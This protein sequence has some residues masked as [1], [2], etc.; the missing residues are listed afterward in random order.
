MTD[1]THTLAAPAASM[2]TSAEIIARLNIGARTFATWLAAGTFPPAD[3]AVGRTRRWRVE[4][5]ERF[6]SGHG[7]RRA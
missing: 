5:I 4:T 1:P 3:L 2:L 6:I 7:G